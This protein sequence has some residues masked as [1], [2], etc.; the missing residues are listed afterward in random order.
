M[1]DSAQE[2][3]LLILGSMDEFVPLVQR[4]RARGVRTLVCDG[5]ATGPARAYADEAYTIDVRNTAELT[6]LCRA[7]G[8]N[9]AIAS[10][11]D[12]LFEA[13][14]TLTHAAGLESY[15]SLEAMACL[16]K[17]DLMK[18][19]LHDLGV[20]TPK[21]CILSEGFSDDD[22][23]A[24]V[25]PCVMKPL[26]GYG[27]HGVFVVHDVAA[28]RARFAQTLAA[29]PGAAT[30]LVL[31]EYD[32]GYEFN[33]ITWVIDGVVHPI[34]IAD[35]EKSPAP[36]GGVPPVSRIVYPSRFTAD[37]CAQAS[38]IAQKIADHLGLVDAPLCLQFFWQPGS[39]IRVCEAVGRLFG[40]EHELVTYGSGLVLEDLLLDMIYDKP[41][42]HRRV[43]AHALAHFTQPCC[44]LYFHGR[45]GI[46][47]NTHAA[48]AAFAHPAVVE[49][50]FYCDEGDTIASGVGQKPY[51]ARAY[52]QAATRD[53][54]DK[55]S[56]QIFRECRVF[57]AQ[58]RNLLY[59]NQLPAPGSEQS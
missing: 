18:A 48:H 44:G 36:A 24:M 3:R 14:C 34:S 50:L 19:M 25:F 26:N 59:K 31:E 49:S 10:F 13:L 9:A 16:R 46:I 7:R 11:S 21:S 57:D 35:R 51:V 55:A 6:A 58:G 41:A 52:V 33:M 28:L 4:A 45:E 27:S 23:A 38:A 2:N 37:V 5:Y 32:S 17:K 40:Y 20:A 56:D 8:I 39:E 42:L 53:A 43:R 47:A 1:A 12:I 15:C 22:V 54:L 30:A 29:S